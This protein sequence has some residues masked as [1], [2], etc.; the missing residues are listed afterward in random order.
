MQRALLN[1]CAD[2]CLW[3][4]VTLKW[5]GDTSVS[6]EAD[7]FMWNKYG[8]KH[9]NNSWNRERRRVV[10]SPTRISEGQTLRVFIRPLFWD[11]SVYSQFSFCSL[12][13]N[14]LEVSFRCTSFWCISLLSNSRWLPLSMLTLSCRLH[15]V[16]GAVVMC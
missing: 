10:Y 8:T 3:L 14:I 4:S 9:I 12:E 15:F 5:L 13:E 2:I 16:V 1:L 11:T 6:T 7:R